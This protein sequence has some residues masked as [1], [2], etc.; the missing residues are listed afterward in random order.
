MVPERYQQMMA[1]AA[2]YGNDRIIVGAHYAMDVLGGRTLAQYDIAH[3][4]ANT[5][6]YVGVKRGALQIDEF[7]QALSDARADLTAALEKKCAGKIAECA[8]KDDGRF[9]DLAKDETFYESILTYG[10][11]TEYPS[12]VDRTEDVAE[13]APEAG[14]LLI[15][16]FPKLTLA[17]ADSILTTTEG[18]GGGYL[19]DGSG[20]GVYSRLDLFKAA[21]DAARMSAK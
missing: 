2:E 17:Q 13:L 12:R 3:L 18:P 5:K 4:L 6:G 20:F 19:D 15:T 7:R 1:R 8:T 14:Y 9:A 21:G 11:P 10:L 16:A